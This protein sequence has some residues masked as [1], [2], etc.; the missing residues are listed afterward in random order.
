MDLVIATEQP[1]EKLAKSLRMNKLSNG[2]VLD[3]TKQAGEQALLFEVFGVGGL[4]T[5]KVFL[6]PNDDG[7]HS[8]SVQLEP[9]IVNTI[10][11]SGF[12]LTE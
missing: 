4:P 10:K 1:R 11:A 3:C 7:T 9:W 2:G 5:T 12:E 6:T 8:L